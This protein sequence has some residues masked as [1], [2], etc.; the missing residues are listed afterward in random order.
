MKR[1]EVT[2]VRRVETVYE[3]E[4]GD[5]FDIDAPGAF[6]AVENDYYGSEFDQDFDL[7]DFDSY[8]EDYGYDEGDE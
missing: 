4:V 1:I 2:I 3:Y 7:G 8:A 6:R 5:D